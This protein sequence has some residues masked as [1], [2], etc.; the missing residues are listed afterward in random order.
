MNTGGGGGGGGGRGPPPQQ[1]PQPSLSPTNGGEFLLQ[2]LQKPQQ[3]NTSTTTT[4]TTT[5]HPLHHLL[6]HNN[7][8]SPPPLDPAVAAMGP[9]ISSFS[10]INGHDQSNSNSNSNSLPPWLLNPSPSPTITNNN[11][12]TPWGLAGLPPPPNLQFTG[13]HHQQHQ[14]LQQ[15]QFFADEFQGFGHL[16]G[17]G[18]LGHQPSVRPQQQK[19]QE[20][21]MMMFG[22]LPSDIKNL[23]KVLNG[24]LLDQRSREVNWMNV[25]DSQFGVQQDGQ[26][27]SSHIWSNA[28]RNLEFDGKLNLHAPHQWNNYP[29]HEQARGGGERGREQELVQP[30]KIPVLEPRNAPPGFPTKPKGLDHQWGSMSGMPELERNVDREES[31]RGK[32]NHK[33][34][35]S[36]NNDEMLRNNLP[37]SGG[38]H[39]DASSRLHLSGQIDHPGPREGSKL[40][41]VPAV[42]IEE[43]LGTLH[44]E[45]F[46]EDSRFNRN[47]NKSKSD[48]SGPN[49]QRSGRGWQDDLSEQLMNSV[50][51]SNGLDKSSTSHYDNSYDKNFRP[52]MSRELRPPGQRMRNH[53]RVVDCRSDIDRMNAPFLAIYESLVPT[54]EEKSKQKQLLTSLEKLVNKEWPTAQLYLYG[55]CANSFGVSKSDIDV[56]LALEEP[57]INKSEILLKLA[58]I[59]QA[60]NLENVQALTRARVPIVKLMDPVT[61]I[62]CDICINNVLAVVNTKLL[63]DYAQIDDRLRQLAFIVKHWAKSRGV[64]VT[65]Q[66]TLSSYA[67]V[68]MCIHFLQQRKPA[69]LPCLQGMEATYVVTVDDIECAYFDQVQHLRDFGARNKERIAAL[70]WAFFDYWA[71]RHDYANGVISVRTGSIISKRAKDWTRRIG[72]DRHL[73]CIEDPFEI[74]H[75]LG[76][77]V[78]KYSIKTLREEF[79][80]AANIMH[81]DPDPCVTLFEP[82][83]PN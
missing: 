34:N 47:E 77:V 17:N 15:S 4:T 40:H 48:A 54:E 20:Q 26:V 10:S 38:I 46:E 58:D 25:V 76:R 32:M 3:Q 78:D 7:H 70:V 49:Y 62:S 59:L 27:K 65:Y 31:S 81:L 19:Q 73:I 28:N 60:D 44:G 33:V 14:Q 22:S 24:N 21:N 82:Y 8:P 53:K 23:E 64:N 18:I 16:G 35:Q 72:N 61:G 56:C 42:D 63:H 69:I 9:T 74:S 2:L 29:N 6:H 36:Y 57:D 75:D 71:Y 30:R 37:A 43:S 41:S 66:G 13:N 51:L 12:N 55:S 1:P 11:N 45:V 79:E 52:D 68:L 83:V 80:R 50:R 5:T 39:A 67:Y